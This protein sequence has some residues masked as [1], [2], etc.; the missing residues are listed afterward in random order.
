[1]NRK[2]F[3]KML[4]GDIDCIEEGLSKG[5][6]IDRFNAIMAVVRFRV[7]NDEV[8]TCLRKLCDDDSRAYRG[9]PD[10]TV[11]NFAIAALDLLEMEKYD[12]DDEYVRE[13]IENNLS[14][15]RG[16]TYDK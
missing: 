9:N 15:D 2:R 12:G 13:L 5:S 3:K 6:V 7:V 10:F 8:E 4:S 11:S 1:M 14:I 16:M